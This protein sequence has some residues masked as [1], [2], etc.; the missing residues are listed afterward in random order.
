MCRFTII[1]INPVAGRATAGRIIS[2]MTVRSGQRH[3][4]IDEPR[5][6]QPEKNRVGAQ[7]GAKTTV[8]QFIVRLA[9][10][11]VARRIAQFG[12]FS[13][14]AF[15]YSQHVSWLR[16]FPAIEWRELWQNAFCSRFFARWWRKSLNQLRL[17]VAVVALSKA[18]I[19]PGNRSVVVKCRSPQESGVRHHAGGNGAR[20]A[21]VATG[22]SAGCSG[23]P[24]I[25]GIH[26]FYVFR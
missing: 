8:A 24:Q 4:G 10:V 1:G 16:S 9:G 22:G 23:D 7:F 13:S 6:L 5:F 18:R 11:L 17:A 26:K 21:G 15:E 25:S 20:L 19:F 14:S 2:R 3:H 12:F